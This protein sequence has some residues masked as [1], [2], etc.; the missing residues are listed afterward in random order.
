M[1]SFEVG[2]WPNLPTFT[3]TYRDAAATLKLAEIKYGK[4]KF[5][6]PNFM[7]ARRRASDSPRGALLARESS[8]P[9]VRVVGAPSPNGPVKTAYS[10]SDGSESP[11]SQPN[12]DNCINSRTRRLAALITAGATS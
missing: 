11:G 10:L 12:P 3:S 8:A 4:R 2:P 1:W 7:G 6:G 9:P 5:E